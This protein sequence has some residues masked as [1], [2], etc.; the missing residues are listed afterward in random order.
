MDNQNPQP[1]V[2][3]IDDEAAIRDMLSRALPRRGYQVDAAESGEAAVA[4][5]KAKEFDVAICDVMM[6]GMD[7]VA[8]L[9]ALKGLR[10]GME[11]VMST[12]FASLDS[13]I[14][15]LKAG[16]YD[17]VSKPYTLD[18]IFGVLEKAL[19]HSRLKAKVS[20]LETANR[21]KSE[22]LANMSHELRTPLNAILGYTSLMLEQVYG[23]V[24]KEQHDALDRVLTNSQNL[25]ALINNILDFS[26]LNAGMMPVFLEEFDAGEL[27]REVARTLQCLAGQ[28]GLAL[29]PEAPASL[30]LRGDKTKVKQIL[31]N[32]AANA[33]KFT[34]TG[35]V[36][37]RAA[38]GPDGTDV[39][40]SVSDTGPGIAPEHLAYIFEK[41][42][43]VDGSVTRTHG[44]TG[45]GLS[46]TKKLCELLDGSITVE[47]RVGEGSTFTARLPAAVKPPDTD[48][49]NRPAG[50]AGR[51]GRKVLL[52]ID[53]DPEVLRLLRDSL[54]GTEYDFCGAV[55]AE[56]GLALARQLKPF[57]I[58]LD[59]L[60]PRRDGWSVLQALKS[61]PELRAIPV[62]ILS[63]LENRALGFSLGVSD[64]IVKPFD[65][66]TLLEKLRGQERLLGRR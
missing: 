10:P 43:Q 8:T 24:P 61:D 62:F 18:H 50:A 20:E 46:I 48:I 2:L 47:S 17:Y 44:G 59:I 36:T 29:A 14:E 40:F 64:Y 6:P 19:E 37:L 3:V 55:S 42:T 5:A 51:G 54:S 30:R 15:S 25:L 9:K 27:V 35:G 22:F 39:A 60:M 12:G 4:Q 31:I 66:Q 45:L 11:V 53:D 16:A 26:K 28:K 58:T 21:L 7:G 65:R 41:F 1:A 23:P 34:Q 49:L 38:A 52:C 32:L 13:A 63:I 33:V 57:V 56:E